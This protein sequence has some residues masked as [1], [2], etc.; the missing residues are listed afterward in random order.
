V[1][2]GRFRFGACGYAG[3]SASVGAATDLSG[4]DA[5][6]S[7]CM[8]IRDAA[9][10]TERISLL[11]TRIQGIPA[12]EA[13]KERISVSEL[14]RRRCM[15][16]PSAD[17]VLLASMAAELRRAAEDARRS[18]EERLTAVREAPAEAAANR[19]ECAA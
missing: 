17:E 6:D 12:S 2:A 15:G 18:L 5:H 13:K 16:T 11:G 10:K 9:V 14:V 19:Q 1:T 7:K 8:H 4:A 3:D